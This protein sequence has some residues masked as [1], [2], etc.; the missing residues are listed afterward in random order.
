MLTPIYIAIRRSES[1]AFFPYAL[2]FAKAVAIDS[3]TVLHFEMGTVLG[4]LLVGLHVA[5]KF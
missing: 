2:P 3:E 1:A 5:T 4:V